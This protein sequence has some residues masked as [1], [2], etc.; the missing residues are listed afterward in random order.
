[1]S[2]RQLVRIA[3]LASLLLVGA[4]L[5]AAAEASIGVG[6]ISTFA[7]SP[8]FGPVSAISIGAAGGSSG[9]V[10]TATLD[11]T[12]YA[13]Y[14][15]TAQNV[16]RR[17]D[18]TTDQGQVVA[19]NGGFG[20]PEDGKPAT[21]T[22]IGPADL[23]SVDA[24]GDMA[25]L[26]ERGLVAFVPVNS[27]TYFGTAMEGGHIYTLPVAAETIALEPNGNL[28]YD[29]DGTIQI[30]PVSSGVTSML[31]SG[32]L[33]NLTI[34]ADPA[35]PG[36]FAYI[37]SES[38]PGKAGHE[39]DYYAAA[40]GTFFGRSMSQ[41][42]NHL[43]DYVNEG[44]LG[45]DS[46]DDGPASSAIVNPESL[47]FDAAGDLLILDSGEDGIH[48]GQQRFVAATSCASGCL[49]GLTATTAGYIY[50]TELPFYPVA[51][52]GD[53]DALAGEGLAGIVLYSRRAPFSAYE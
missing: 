47:A 51:V 52:A 6:T 21:E 31:A 2:Y 11:G 40:A 44:G 46:G 25:I 33:D 4:L 3:C 41:G 10:A 48:D 22:T 5:P 27:G 30:D 29:Y 35:H 49:Y 43:A 23:V 15:G 32:Y 28:I 37:D 18:L 36:N 7:G 12:Q 42:E 38:N 17:I 53:E 26:G 24:N 16:V 20:P 50:R 9:E 19:G 45:I 8:V 34:A 14:A 13:Y 1:V 39:I